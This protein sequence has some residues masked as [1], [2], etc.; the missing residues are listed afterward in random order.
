MF[1]IHIYWM[2]IPRSCR[3]FPCDALVV[4]W[5]ISTKWTISSQAKRNFGFFLSLQYRTINVIYSQ[6][7]FFFFTHQTTNTKIPAF[8][9]RWTNIPPNHHFV[10]KLEIEIILDD[11]PHSCNLCWGIM[12]HDVV[13]PSIRWTIPNGRRLLVQIL[14]WCKLLHGTTGPTIFQ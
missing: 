7:R 3:A 11:L 14:Y 9:C 12:C 10:S 4:W 5:H 2:S 8:S 1:T 6:K 13:V